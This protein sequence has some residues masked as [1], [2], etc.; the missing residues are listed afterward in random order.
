MR[1]LTA[2]LYLDGEVDPTRETMMRR[3]IEAR[4][5]AESCGSVI[6]VGH[7][8]PATLEFLMAS[9]DSFRVWG[10]RPVALGDLLR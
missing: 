3:L 1:C 8:R 10:C 5:I 6:L 2:D 7:A 9:Q 4:R